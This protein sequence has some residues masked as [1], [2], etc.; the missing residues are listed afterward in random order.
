MV[1]F[2]TCLSFFLLLI[3]TTVTAQSENDKQIEFGNQIFTALQ[4]NDSQLYRNLY[5]T[6]EEYKGLIQ[7]MADA[8]IDGLTQKQADDYL[9]DYKLKADST[10]HAEFTDL[11][12][13]ADSLGI[14]WADAKF[15]SFEGIAAYPEHI[16]VKYLDG[17]LKFNTARSV[18]IVDVEAFEF[19]PSFKLQAVKNIRKYE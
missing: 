12:K 14:D 5:P 10:Y 3:S 13:Q 15:T 18:F 1:R 4:T 11:Q 19:S 17:Y 6:F 16:S 9:E 7:Q 2:K 8:K